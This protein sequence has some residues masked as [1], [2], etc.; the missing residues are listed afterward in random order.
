MIR[1]D[2]MLKEDIKSIRDVID[3]LDRRIDS[4]ETKIWEIKNPPK[5]K[6]GEK[7]SYIYHSCP[8]VDGVVVKVERTITNIMY[9]FPPENTWYT[10]FLQEN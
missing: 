1:R 5:F 10:L 9:C 3:R 4:L 8:K 7:V 6:I 2:K